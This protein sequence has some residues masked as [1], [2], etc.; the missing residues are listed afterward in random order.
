MIRKYN[1][2]GSKITIIHAENKFKPLID[3]VK[4]DLEIKMN[5]SN[6]GDH[7]PKRERKNI[8]SSKKISQYHRLTFDNI[9]KV[10]IIYL[11][12]EVFRKLNYFPVKGGLSPYYIP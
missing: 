7:V 1:S 4:D 2:S 11:S 6:P 12:F 9:T 5:S 3:K 10:I 8:Q